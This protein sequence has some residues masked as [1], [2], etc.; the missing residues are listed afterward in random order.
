M[1]I[2]DGWPE[3]ELS[4]ALPPLLFGGTHFS[5]GASARSVGGPGILQPC[6]QVLISGADGG[7]PVKDPEV[8]WEK[9]KL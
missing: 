6:W 8:D 9:E 3:K 4:Q 2:Q 1:A 7:P 5:K